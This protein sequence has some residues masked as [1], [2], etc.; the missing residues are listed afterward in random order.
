LGTLLDQ[1][2][3]QS[4]VASVLDTTLLNASVKTGFVLN[5]CFVSN[6]SRIFDLAFMAMGIST[7][8]GQPPKID[9]I[10]VK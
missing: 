9:H 8:D 5:I 6:K 1:L 7:G 4:F 3:Q 2:G 10:Q